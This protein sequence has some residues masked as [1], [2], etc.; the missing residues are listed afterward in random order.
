LSD[1]AAAE[2]EGEA[3]DAAPP[4]FG[5]ATLPPWIVASREFHDHPRALHIVGVRRENRSLFALLAALAEPIE[6]AELFDAYMSAKFRL[7]EWPAATPGA[8]RSLRNS[9]LRFLRG[10]GVDSNGI[11]G[12]VL[13]GWV[14][15]RLGI[16]PSYH[17]RPV[18]SGR[19]S[20]L[21]FA[22]ERMRGH[23]RTNAIDAQVDLLFEYCQYE[24]ARRRLRRVVLYRGTHEF[25]EQRVLARRQDA[26]FV[27]RLNNLCSF[28]AERERAWEFGLRV[29]RVEVPAQR[30]LYFAGLLPKSILRGEDEYLVIGGEHW[31]TEVRF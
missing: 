14:E 24:L 31:A 25:E 16:P 10:W 6:R 23:A 15:S 26:E 30:I 4:S 11:E 5:R 9:Y 18:E 27:V 3:E 8:R 7:D 21:E 20:Y 19:R 12:A 2:C 22:S 29:L 13:K 17:R 1:D 28:S